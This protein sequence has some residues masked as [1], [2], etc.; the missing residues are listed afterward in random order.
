MQ[1]QLGDRMKTAESIFKKLIVLPLC[2]RRLRKI[3]PK[4]IIQYVKCETPCQPYAAGSLQIDFPLTPFLKAVSCQCT[5]AAGV[6]S[7]GGR[8]GPR[9]KF[10]VALMA[11][12]Q[13][14]TTSVL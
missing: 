2:F 11:F 14:Q 10:Y 4:N 7:A 13:R 3:D 1:K 12:G 6:L 9:A 8:M 5:P